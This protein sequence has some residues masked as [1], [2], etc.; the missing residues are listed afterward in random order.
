MLHG[1]LASQQIQTV[2]QRRVQLFH[3]EAA[4]IQAVNGCDVQ[5]GGDGKQQAGGVGIALHPLGMG[6]DGFKIHLGQHFHQKIAAGSAPD[7]LDPAVLAQAFQ[8][9]C[10]L[11]TGGAG[12]I[13]QAHVGGL[14]DLPATGMK[15]LQ[16]LQIAHQMAFVQTCRRGGDANQV[17]FFQKF[18]IDHNFSSFFSCFGLV[19]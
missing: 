2:L 17:I 7:H 16:R 11:M 18:R 3:V 19:K 6:A 15:M 5:F 10:P 1:K 12:Q 9:L 13:G 14:G 8:L 4:G